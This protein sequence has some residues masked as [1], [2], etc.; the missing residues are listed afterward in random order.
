MNQREFRRNCKC[1]ECEY[2]K[3]EHGE[4]DD[5]MVCSKKEEVREDIQ[6]G[7]DRCRYSR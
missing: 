4:Y 3:L 5:K 2:M 7:K 1:T 6:S